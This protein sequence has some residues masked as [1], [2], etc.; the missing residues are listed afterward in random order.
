MYGQEGGWMGG[1]IGGW[2]GRKDECIGGMGEW[3]DG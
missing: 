2:D 1:W 3:V